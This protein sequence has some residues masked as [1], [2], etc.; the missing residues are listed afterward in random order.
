MSRGTLTILGG[1]ALVVAA[2]LGV[3]FLSTPGDD[4]AA[5]MPET[6]PVQVRG[7][8]LPDFGGIEGDPAVG[9]AAPA[10]EG[11]SFDESPV[12]IAPGEEPLAI[13][14][15]AHWCPHCQAEV[16][17]LTPWLEAGGDLHG[18]R[19]VSVATGNDPGRPNW[20]P[21]AWLEGEGW[22]IEVLLDDE[23]LTAARAYG[24]ASFPF[25]VFVDDQGDVLVR[26][27]G[28]IPPETLERGLAELAG[29]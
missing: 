28:R 15:L 1:A 17:A 20:P 19:L 26:V 6:I 13:L 18:F 23:E 16:S 10:V 25:W 22:P 7:E 29:S 4:P 24:L 11:I 3:A 2:L 27:A 9:L 8:A 14:F 5:P 21:S 12:A